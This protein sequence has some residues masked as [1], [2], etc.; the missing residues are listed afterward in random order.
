MVFREGGL[1]D[2]SQV[3]L[4]GNHQLGIHN[5][6]P[7]HVSTITALTILGYIGSYWDNGNYYNGLHGLY[8]FVGSEVIKSCVQSS[9]GPSGVKTKWQ[10]RVAP[11]QLHT[12]KANGVVP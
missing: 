10:A 11:L 7:W 3:A 6:G 2:S 1:G 4:A 5:T 9:Y 12:K 8:S